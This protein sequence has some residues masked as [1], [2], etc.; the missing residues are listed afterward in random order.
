MV[1]A[2]KFD[3]YTGCAIWSPA[4]IVRTSTNVLVLK[5]FGDTAS[6]K[7]ISKSS[8]EVYPHGHFTKDK[9]EW[10]LNLKKGDKVDYALLP[11]LWKNMEIVEVIDADGALT[12]GFDPLETGN[13]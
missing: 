2:I 6:E 10:R 7:S 13:H 9:F 5:Y 4:K 1:D 3:N 12:L 8:L 11:D